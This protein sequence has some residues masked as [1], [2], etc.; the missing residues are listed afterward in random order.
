MPR[1]EVGGS[2]MNILVILERLDRA[3][4]PIRV[5]LGEEG[6]LAD[7]LR[8]R[9][10]PVEVA[11]ASFRSA[12]GIAAFTRVAREHG[13]RVLHLYGS[14]TLAVAARALKIAVVET[15]NLLRG[16]LGGG[17]VRWPVLDRNLIRLDHVVIVPSEAMRDQLV[18]RGVPADKVRLVR[19]GIDVDRFAPRPRDPAVRASLGIA[20]DAFVLLNIGRLVAVK[21]Q[22]DLLRAFVRV[23]AERPG[24]VLLIAG[25]GPER[26]ALEQ[27][28]RELSIAP[29]VKLLGNRSDVPELLRASD[30]LVQS[31]REEALA[32]VVCEALAAERPVVATDA[33]GTR[34]VV[35]TD[36]GL[37]VPARDPDALARGVL[38]LAREPERARSLARAGRELM[39]REY[40]LEVTARGTEAAYREALARAGGGGGE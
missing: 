33:G 1:S 11:G 18:A 24:A 20:D 13:A 29:A 5:L 15:V 4:F 8:A 21:G 27:L 10:V 7:A 28:A 39:L 34:E 31:S 30:L 14:R 17:F 26:P 3:A 36:T 25:E 19:T 40:T 2:Q 35:R 38:D 22:E 23:R 37:L 16:P 32:T 6:P 12:R 9:S